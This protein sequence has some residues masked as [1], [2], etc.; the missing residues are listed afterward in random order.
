MLSTVRC[1]LIRFASL[2]QE[3]VWGGRH[4]NSL[5][6]R[7][8]PDQNAVYGESWEVC[9]RA[10]AQS[11]VISGKFKGWSLHELWQNARREVFGMRSEAHGSERFPLLIKILDAQKNL[12]VQVHPDDDTAP[13]LNGEAKSEAWFVT[14]AGPQAR[15]FAGLLPGTTKEVFAGSLADNT[16]MDHVNALEVKAG[17]CLYIPGGTIHAIGE[18][19]VIF[20]IQQNSDTTYRIFDWNRP[21][22]DGKPRVLHPEESMKALNFG[23]PPCLPRRLDNGDLFEVPYFKLKLSNLKPS[24]P[25]TLVN[26]DH[27]LIGAVI[28]GEVL[29][30]GESFNAGDFFLVPA[31]PGADARSVQASTQEASL[32]WISL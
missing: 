19:V 18:G 16:L 21:D 27:F 13:L 1:P 29:I 15:L 9:D 31:S 30:D 25:S 11:V 22:L 26:E 8:L 5:Y 7:N 20:E 6:G 17:D 24:E 2:Y 14:H 32:L 10:E 23:L 3:R 4:F 12:S 28:S